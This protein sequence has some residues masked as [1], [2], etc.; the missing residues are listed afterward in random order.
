MAQADDVRSMLASVAQLTGEPT[1][2]TL[3]SG[4]IVQGTHGRATLDDTL[5]AAGTINGDEDTLTFV[6]LDVPGMKAGWVITWNAA[7]W[8]IRHL[9]ALGGGAALKA[10]LQEAP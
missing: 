6:A 1:A 4:A 3:P 2:V 8:T 9:Q 10:F 5:L 7:P